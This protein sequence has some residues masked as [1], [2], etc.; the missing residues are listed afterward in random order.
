M[1]VRISVDENGY[2]PFI[3]VVIP[4]YNAEALIV[5]TLNSVCVQTYT[6]FE[7]IL[8]DDGSTD[9]SA[10]ICQEYVARD[11]RFRLVQQPNQGVSK[12][13]NHGFEYVKGDYV[14]FLDSDDCWF[15]DK[16]EWDV[17]TIQNAPEKE[18]LIYSGVYCVGPNNRLTSVRKFIST[19]G[20]SPLMTIL[21]NNLMIP[22]STLMH[23]K[24]FESLK[25]FPTDTYHEDRVFFIRACN[26]FPA[27]STGE[28]SI[29]YREDLGGR[30]R[31]ILADYD[32]AVQAEF[33]VVDVLRNDLNQEAISTLEL[34]QKRSVF[35]RFLRYNF[36]GHAKR[37]APLLPEGTLDHD[38]K[39][40]LSKLSLALNINILY[41]CQLIVYFVTGQI[42]QPW[43]YWKSAPLRRLQAI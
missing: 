13:R 31:R 8:V 33:G 19:N 5:P 7:V 12:A 14:T 32:K 18:A 35:N 1:S 39:G 22:S 15:P 20:E 25:G 40:L 17:S 6:N 30:L 36:L 23:R 37:Y 41:L 43:W 11:S 42:M 9:N 38:L 34:F 29:V 10:S 2:K 16:L 28:R 4:V 27:Y 24:V 3:S 26:R 21:V